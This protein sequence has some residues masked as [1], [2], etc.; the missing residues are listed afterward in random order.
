MTQLM[1]I[2]HPF[3]FFIPIMAL[4]VGIRFLTNQ[5][6]KRGLPPQDWPKVALVVLLVA[7]C[8]LF[9]FAKFR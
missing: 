9:A 3:L 8:L 6:R 4:F 2:S 5:R 1:Q 7:L